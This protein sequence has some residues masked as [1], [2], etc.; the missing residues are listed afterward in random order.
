MSLQVCI[1]TFSLLKRVILK[2]LIEAA[3]DHWTQ[4]QGVGFTVQYVSLGKIKFVL[5]H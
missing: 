5:Q 4:Q 3:L 2:Q 1:K